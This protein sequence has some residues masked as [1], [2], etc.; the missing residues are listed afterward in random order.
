MFALKNIIFAV[1]F[2]YLISSTVA[3]I[4]CHKS[5]DASLPGADFSINGVTRRCIN[6]ASC[7]RTFGTI[8]GQPGSFA[9]CVAA[10]NEAET[11]GNY[12]ACKTVT[13]GS[14]EIL[15]S[16]TTCCCKTNL[17]NSATFQGETPQTL[18]Q[19]KL[20]VVDAADFDESLNNA[21]RR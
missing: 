14:G 12:P 3:T 5:V 19:A 4:V 11:C 18:A 8:N 16:Y 6:A 2:C 20:E 7:A 17:C 13:T 15:N 10:E 21:I 1:A 9:S